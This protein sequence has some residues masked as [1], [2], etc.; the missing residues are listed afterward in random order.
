MR[1]ALKPELIILHRVVWKRSK[2]LRGH[3][4]CGRG[5]VPKRFSAWHRVV[6]Y[7]GCRGAKLTRG[8]HAKTGDAFKINRHIFCCH[9]C[10]DYRYRLFIQFLAKN[11]A[12]KEVLS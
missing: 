10:C 6:F 3:R 11:L 2:N 7:D 8:D 4:A 5:F 9:N 1:V 12:L